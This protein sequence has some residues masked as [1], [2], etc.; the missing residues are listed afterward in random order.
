MA[1]RD[2][3]QSGVDG[4]FIWRA[5][6]YRWFLEQGGV[7]SRHYFPPPRILPSN[8]SAPL[9]APWDG[10][11][12]GFVSFWLSCPNSVPSAPKGLSDVGTIPFNFINEN[13][14]MSG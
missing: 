14:C 4:G 10:F 12:K 5:T 2:C 1:R 6:S 7:D 9:S 13:C 11:G 8:F 3:G